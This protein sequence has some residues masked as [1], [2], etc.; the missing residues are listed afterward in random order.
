[1]NRYKKN[2]K[3][4]SGILALDYMIDN[5][6]YDYSCDTWGNTLRSS[7]YHS[8]KGLSGQIKY[9]KETFVVAH[10]S[11]RQGIGGMDEGSPSFVSIIRIRSRLI[12]KEKAPLYS[13]DIWCEGYQAT[14]ESGRAHL[15]SE[16]VSG[17]D[18]KNACCKHFKK[19][20]KFNKDRLSYW[21]YKLY[22][23]EIDA[24]K[25]FG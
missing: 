22:D 21:A 10:H 16:N 24:K 8:M 9:H 13:Y 4:E 5:G 2:W 23:N 14:G 17:R 15:M 7:H 3:V 19:D 12:N 20:N 25:S 1:M 6:E 11:G 18:F